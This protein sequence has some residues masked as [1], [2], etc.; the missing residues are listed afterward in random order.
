MFPLSQSDNQMLEKSWITPEL[1]KSAGFHRVSSIDGG[2]LIGRNGSGDYSGIVIPYIWPGVPGIRENQI[3]LDH[4]ELE[5][6]PDGT[7]KEKQKYLFAPGRANILYIPPGVTLEMLAEINLPIVICEGAKKSLALWRL[8]TEGREN[9]LFVPIAISGVW[10][11]RGTVGKAAGADGTRTPVKGVIPDFDKIT[12]QRIVYIIF[13]SDKKTNSSVQAAERDLAKELKRRGA[14]VKI[15]DLPDLSGLGKTGADD[16]LAHP[17]GGPERMQAL[18]D[19]AREYEPDLLK[20]LQNDHG[21]AERLITLS[22]D[23]LRYCHPMRKWI[24][25][26]GRR[27]AVDSSKAAYKLAKDAMLQYVRQAYKAENQEHEKYS[28][29]SLD[30]KRINALLES[31]QCEI[32]IDPDK[33]DSH[34][35]FLNCLN[36]IVD[37]R[38]AELQPH[39]PDRYITKLVHH[40]YN[41]G[42]ICSI[43]KTTLYQLM[44]FDA[45]KE[46]AERLVSWLQKAFGYSLTSITREKAVFICWGPTD[47]GKSTIL[48]TFRTILEEYSSLL[49]IDTLMVRREETNNSLSD[50]SDLR[51]CRFVQT[52]ETEKGQRLAEG[53]LKRISQGLG[54]IKA[55][56]KY[57]NPIEFLE[58]HKL[59][60]DANHKPRVKGNDGATWNRLYPIPFTVQIPKAEQDKSLPDKLMAEAEGIL[61]WAVAG[62]VRWYRE[63]LGKPE[64]IESANREWRDDEDLQGRFIS[65]CLEQGES[66]TE[67][68]RVYK[69]YRWWCEKGGE[70]P[71]TETAFGRGMTER[72]YE[73][74]K[75]DVTRRTTY[76]NLSIVAAIGTDF[77]ADQYSKKTNKGLF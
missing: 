45:N 13:D 68:S 40:P 17:D 48:T 30:S 31:A 74:G 59:W 56:R 38:T 24:V 69:L 32:F 75:D 9:P 25:W 63:E 12:W 5:L 55:C 71:D 36:G 65:E 21:N 6:K 11:W 66:N 19:A 16:F 52:S 62:A 15:V 29:Q 43:W 14:I 8:A 72:G 41:P 44:G 49:Q 61:A 34:P 39:R 7:T 18:I 70:R 26:D 76:R 42:S 67:A 22:G 47:A 1:A 50:L 60:L 53:K 46:R 33:L 27:W 28:R 3:R 10:N 57:E 54:K 51:G 35:Y 58:T 64:E 20:H 37:L 2:Q 4:P 23:L 73:R 77:D